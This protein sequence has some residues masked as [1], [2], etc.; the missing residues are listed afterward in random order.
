[1]RAGRLVELLLRLQL[2]GGAS[3]SELADAFEVSVRTIYRDVDALSGAGVP[4]HTEVGR[5]GGIRIDPS[6]RVAGLPRLDADEARGVLFAILPAVASQLGFDAGVTD[7]TVLPAME[8]SAETAARVVHERLLVEPTHWF[9]PPDGTA[10]LADVARGVW[11]ARELRLTYR[12]REV[13]TQPLGLILKGD[14][15]YLLG[16]V[17]HDRERPQRLFR[18]SRVEAVELLAQRFDRPPNFDLATA[19]A[20]R[21]RSFMA[22]LPDYR[23][24]VRVAPDAEALLAMLDEGAPELPLSAAVARDQHGWAVVELRFERSVDGVMRQLLRLGGGVEVLAPPELRAIMVD[25]VGEL[26]SVYGTGGG[27]LGPT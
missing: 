16:D 14:T 7:H 15:W 6:Y 5:N 3:A 9:V 21:Q 12:S 8:N 4:I 1:M 25:A 26:A 18:V 23:V 20:E 17:R 11:E 19:W 2:Q 24:M 22:S 13:V 10:A 27:S